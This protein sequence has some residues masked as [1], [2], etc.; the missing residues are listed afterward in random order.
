MVVPTADSVANQPD[1]GAA[2]IAAARA[3]GAGSSGA[4]SRLGGGVGRGGGGGGSGGGES[5]GGGGGAGGGGLP[6]AAVMAAPAS[7]LEYRLYHT[8]HRECSCGAKDCKGLDCKAKGGASPLAFPQYLPPSGNGRTQGN[9]GGNGGAA[10]KRRKLSDMATSR[11][12]SKMTASQSLMVDAAL[13][14]LM[15]G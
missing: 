3:L 11:T 5:G 4:G 13:M 2:A 1:G 6:A 9:N 15:H 7:G 14:S 12:G 8:Q 10:K